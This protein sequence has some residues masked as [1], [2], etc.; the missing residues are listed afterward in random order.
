M[1][2]IFFREFACDVDLQHLSIFGF[3]HFDSHTSPPLQVYQGV[4]VDP[5]ITVDLDLI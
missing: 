2:V 1:L 5:S 4:A 3:L